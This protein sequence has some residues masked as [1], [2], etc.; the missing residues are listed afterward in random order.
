MLIQNPESSTR[1]FALFLFSFPALSAPPAIF[2]I[3]QL[4]LPVVFLAET[5]DFFLYFQP[6]IGYNTQDL[7]GL[8]AEGAFR[9][10]VDSAD[11]KFNAPQQTSNPESQT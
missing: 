3:H 9:T 5:T 7:A 8:S 6:K 1:L 11:P 4:R 2:T 10:E